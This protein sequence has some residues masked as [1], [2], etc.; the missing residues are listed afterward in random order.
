[1]RGGECYPLPPLER[2]TCESES[3]SLP[4]PTAGRSGYNRSAYS[5]APPR[6]A[7]IGLATR[8]LLPTPTAGDAKNTRNATAGRS[9]P[10]GAHAGTTLADVAHGT[11]GKL[12]PAFVE[13]MQGY[14]IGWTDCAGSATPGCRSKRPKHGGD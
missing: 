5:G 13:W 10:T 6:Y 7:L 3:G 4:T 12:H 1:M 14:P 11:G 2:R 8:G 9:A